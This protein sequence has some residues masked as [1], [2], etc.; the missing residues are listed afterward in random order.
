MKMLLTNLAIFYRSVLP[1]ILPK[2]GHRERRMSGSGVIGG[3]GGGN[4]TA[5]M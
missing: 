4:E 3:E 5:G 2:W 1:L